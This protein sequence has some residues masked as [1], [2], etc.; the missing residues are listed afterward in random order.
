MVLG[1]TGGECEGL[2]QLQ[3]RVWPQELALREELLWMAL[4]RKRGWEGGREGGN[5]MMDRIVDK[6]KEAALGEY[7][8]C[9]PH[10]PIKNHCQRYI[11]GIIMQYKPYM[12][13]LIEQPPRKLLK[14]STTVY[15][16]HYT[17]IA[18]TIMHAFT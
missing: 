2:D 14:A 8:H 3:E 16:L 9:S 17:G 15:R 6:A 12:S 7:I 11:P 4:L 10:A 18:S 13:Y 5:L 1:T